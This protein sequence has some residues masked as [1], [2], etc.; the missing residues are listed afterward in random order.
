MLAIVTIFLSIINIRSGEAAAQAENQAPD[1]V[2]TRVCAVC[3]KDEA[4]AWGQ[5]H[6][7]LAWTEP[8][9]K[10][11]LG[12]FED[13]TYELHGITTRFFKRGD[14]F[15]VETDG[16]DGA[17]TIYEIKG[18]VGTDP[19][20]QYL[21]ESE[22]GRLQA[23]DT[24]WNIAENRWYHLYPDQK[25]LA[26]NGLHWT[27]PYK[28]WNSRCAE[29][30]ATGYEKRY[31]PARRRYTSRQQEIGVGCEACHGPGSTHV[32]WAGTIPIDHGV[33]KAGFVIDFTKN[34]AET[35]IQQCAGCHSRR[36]PVAA[37]SPE[38]GTPYH[39]AYRLALLRPSLYHPDGSILD[40][41]YV[42][43][44]F[45]QSKMYAKGV[46]CSDCH[47]AHSA[48]L[49]MEG[50]A[51]CIQCHSPAGNPRFPTLRRAAYDASAHHFHAPGSEGAQCK[52][53]HMIERTYMQID[54]RRDHSFRIPRPDLTR[55][56]AAPNACN[57]CH[58][59][60][61]A[62][63]AAA[64]I[65]LRYPDSKRRGPHFS[66]TLFAGRQD[67]ANSS[68]AL[69]KIAENRDNAAIVRATALELLRTAT[70]EEI[71]TRSAG[72][73][74]NTDPMIRQAAIALQRGAPPA[75]RLERL[76][77]MLDDPARSVRIAA[78]RTFVGARVSQLPLN[79]AQ[80]F[81]VA[82][83]EFR[84]SLL[85][86]S[87]YPETH[88]VL[89]GTALGMRNMQAA[90]AAFREAVSLDPQLAQAWTMIVRIRQA[91]G[92]RAAARKALEEALAANPGNPTLLDLDRILRK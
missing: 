34:S 68:D 29:C 56:T 28:T 42:Y 24:A 53:C 60:R 86:K 32:K 75:I 85:A 89:G 7:A 44:S 74:M 11:V 64:E 13:A 31:D 61:S 80:R 17:A 40:E 67:A 52:S 39:D 87:D 63:W 55:E 81:K 46:R 78:A 57:D 21:V 49:R 4:D 69:L 3:H 36:E 43:G 77:P 83:A 1:Y 47:D 50:N 58:T 16:P 70:T 48:E 18:V 54:P 2:G 15:F 10:T 19:L 22:P 41:V 91:A 27:G 12:N 88:L 23:L 51:L 66:Q 8:T 25:L 59:D 73:L 14:A 65:A 62:K 92:N 5:S 9:D 45:L 79:V 90:E 26:G 38:P 20:Q 76:V 37:D 33:P 30:H 35:E 71:A 72:Y 6:H 82:S 84:A